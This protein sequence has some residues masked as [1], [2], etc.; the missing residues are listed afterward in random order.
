[1]SSQN[2]STLRSSS[3]LAGGILVS[4][5]LLARVFAGGGD[6]DAGPG[7]ESALRQTMDPA[8]VT[9]AIKENAQALRSFSWQQRMQLQVRAR[10]KR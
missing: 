5:A 4:L 9:A 10:R 7:S 1:M 3:G 8:K 6:R 2:S